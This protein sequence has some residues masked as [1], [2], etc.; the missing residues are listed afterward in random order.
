M[1]TFMDDKRNFTIKLSIHQ[2]IPTISWFISVSFSFSLCFSALNNVLRTFYFTKDIFFFV[3]LKWSMLIDAWVYRSPFHFV[4][5]Y[6]ANPWTNFSSAL[7]NWIRIEIYIENRFKREVYVHMHVNSIQFNLFIWMSSCILSN[8]ESRIM[9]TIKR[10]TLINILVRERFLS[11][12]FI[13]LINRIFYPQNNQ[14]KIKKTLT[15]KI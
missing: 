8:I 14:P 9:L 5:Y 11:F 7:R 3:Y 2:P 10:K 13:S 12:T 1:S 6:R 4:Y 15:V